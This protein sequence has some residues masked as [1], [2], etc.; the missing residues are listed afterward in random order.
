MFRLTARRTLAVAIV[1]SALILAG[2]KARLAATAKRAGVQPAAADLVLLGGRITTVEASQPD[3]Q[4]LAARGG[5]I[6]AVGTDADVKPFIGPNTR[7]INLEGRRAIP[8]FVEGHAHFTGIGRTKLNLELMPTKTW[9]EIVAMVAAA[10]KKAQPGDW[11]LGRGW[12]QEK[13]T[14]K[15]QPNVQ[16]FPTHH[17]LSE[18]APENPV[19]LTHASGHAAFANKKAMELSGITRDTPNPPGGEIVKDAKGEPIGALIETAQRLVDRKSV[20]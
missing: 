18:V 2:A 4:A 11:I 19:L 7:V 5:R 20:V 6:V 12:H 8:G 1:V 16:G 3:V 17:Q 13:W 15:P 9:D 10:A 14:T